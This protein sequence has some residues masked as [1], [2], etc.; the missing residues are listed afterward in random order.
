VELRWKDDGTVSRALVRGVMKV[1]L[2]REMVGPTW[3][4]YCDH[5]GF[6]D[7]AFREDGMTTVKTIKGHEWGN[8]GRPMVDIEWACGD[9]AKLLVKDVMEKKGDA[10]G[11]MAA[12]VAYC[13]GIG[14][15]DEAFRKGYVDRIAR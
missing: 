14:M 1:Q 13:D 11:F 10:N 8:C 5:L 3:L 7:K 9:L 12:W 2:E 15:T 4:Q 6:H